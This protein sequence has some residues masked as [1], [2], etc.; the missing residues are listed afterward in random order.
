MTTLTPP[1]VVTGAAGFIG[2]RLVE[3]VSDEKNHLLSVDDLKHFH[4]RLEHKGLDFGTEI[5]HGDLLDVLDNLPAPPKV[6]FHLGAC[7]D[8]TEMDKD[9]LAEMN[10]E[11]SKA[12]WAYCANNGVPFIYASSAATYGDG[13]NGYDDDESRLSGLKPLNPY[14]DSKHQFDLWALEKEKDGMAPPAWSGFKF[15]NVYGF[16]ESHKARM[17]S[18]VVQAFD[19][20]RSTGKVRLFKS[21][22]P[23]VPHGEQ[24]RDFVYVDDVVRI[25]LYAA[26]KPLRRGI[27]NLGSGRARTFV[28]LARAVFHS[29]DLPVAIDFID[30]PRGLAERY[31]YFTEAKME[32]LASAGFR[33][34]FH[35]LE[36]GVDKYVAK[37]KQFYT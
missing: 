25:L 26:K 9:Y 36:E 21:Y 34:P 7:T 35:S 6:I 24:K 18:V 20:I 28:D 13:S 4:A 37:L 29:L 23:D 3:A 12:L 22:R 10:L 32:K 5:H 17:S 8:T 31:Q 11:Y 15:F 1:I 33:E 2:A 27:Y 16:G 14:G 30:M 19:Q